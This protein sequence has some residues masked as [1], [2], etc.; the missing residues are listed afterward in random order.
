MTWE[1]TIQM[2][3]DNPEFN[4][5]II[6]AYF[7]EDLSDNVRRFGQSEE[8]FETMELFRQYSNNA[9]TI[10]DIGSGNGISAVNFALKNFD[11]TVIEPDPSDSIGAGA[12][13]KLKHELNLSNLK[14]FQI[15]AED[16]P[17][18][19]NQFDIVYVRQAMHHAKDLDKFIFEAVRVL[20]P[21]GLL[22][23][24]RDHVIYNEYDKNWFL[25]NHPLH[26]YYGGENAFTSDQYVSA[27]TSA[28]ASVVKILRYY[29][30]IINYFPLTREEKDRMWDNRVSTFK[31]S[32]KKKIGYFSKIPGITRTLL[33][34]KNINYKTVYDE[35]KVPGRMYTYIAIKS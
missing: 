12:I 3:R 9:E 4:E 7:D 1:E 17:F 29:D 19:D 18:D 22:L 25:K 8:F 14:I 34:L 31:K 30:S 32:I 21:G 28:G 11:V 5:L 27:M 2:I 15:L 20:K 16:M 33:A 6:H 13:G 24:V 10:L 26:K 23:T 35:S